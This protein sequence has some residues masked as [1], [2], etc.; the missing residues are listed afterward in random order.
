MPTPHTFPDEAQFAAYAEAI[1]ADDGPV[2]MLN[3]NKFRDVAVYEDGRDAGGASGRDTYLKYGMVA[4]EAIRWLGGEVLW[5]TDAIAPIIGCEHD[6]YDEV[7]AVWYPSR[8]AFLRLT[9]YPGYEDALAHRD[10]A[11]ERAAV[12]PC[13]GSADKVLRGPFG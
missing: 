4:L 8:S 2:V 3:L 9:D 6:A 1:E 10:A 11:L 12:L 5:M 7:L 13:A